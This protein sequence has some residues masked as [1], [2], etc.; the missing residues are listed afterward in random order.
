MKMTS[1]FHINL[2]E[3]RHYSQHQHKLI[4]TQINI[5]EHNNN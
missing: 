1:Q 5:L 4:I 3:I 2:G